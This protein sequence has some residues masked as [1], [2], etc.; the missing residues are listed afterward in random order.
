MTRLV[1]FGCSYTYG[2]LLQDCP[3]DSATPS[4]YSWPKLLSNKLNIDLINCSDPGA[5][6]LE[7]LYKILNFKFNHDDLIV[8]LWTMFSR[9]AII[10][11]SKIERYGAWLPGY[12]KWLGAQTEEHLIFMSWVYIHHAELYLKSLNLNNYS[13]I[14]EQAPMLKYKP[15]FIKL[16]NLKDVKSTFNPMLDLCSDKLHPGPKTHEAFSNVVYKDITT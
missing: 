15:E 3:A 4:K 9:G 12:S 14:A 10:D 13:Y 11:K 2:S 1:A 5:S 7:I 16:F 8:I 6:N